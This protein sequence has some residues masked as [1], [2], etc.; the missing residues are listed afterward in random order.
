MTK[1]LLSLWCA[2]L[3][4]FALSGCLPGGVPIQVEFEE[5]PGV[6]PD[7]PVVFKGKKIGTVKEVKVGSSI[8]VHAE[9]DEKELAGI[10]SESYGK[11]G[12]F[13][14]SVSLEIHVLKPSAPPL[15]A[16]ATI[17]GVASDLEELGLKAGDT[18]KDALDKATDKMKDLL[19]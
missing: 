2:L 7:N 15:Q 19:K 10:S 16:E 4:P 18:A 8:R 1:S 12:T 14:G 17:K 6:Y 11:P 5:A 9:V 3:V 13:E